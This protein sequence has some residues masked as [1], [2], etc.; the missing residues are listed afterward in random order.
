MDRDI[1]VDQ[2]D[3]ESPKY[4]A[5]SPKSASPKGGHRRDL[6]ELSGSPRSPTKDADEEE[7][8]DEML[9]VG[10]VVPEENISLLQ[11]EEAP[12]GKVCPPFAPT[13]GI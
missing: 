1:S 10:A 5:G 13:D 6:G 7:A 8:V 11:Q 3:R 9:G 12:V 4:T 2:R